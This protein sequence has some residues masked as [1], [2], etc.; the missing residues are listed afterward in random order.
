MIIFDFAENSSIS[1]SQQN[2]VRGGIS[3]VASDPHSKI[4]DTWRQI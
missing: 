3:V 4:Y 2:F 1:P